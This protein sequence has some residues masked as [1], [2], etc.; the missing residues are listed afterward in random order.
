MTDEQGSTLLIVIIFIIAAALLVLGVN[1]SLTV[2]EASTSPP[3]STLVSSPTKAVP[4]APSEEAQRKAREQTMSLAISY[5]GR[6]FD[7]IDHRL[8]TRLSLDGV[9]ITGRRILQGTN[10]EREY[11][12]AVLEHATRSALQP[13]ELAHIIINEP[14]PEY[15]AERGPVDQQIEEAGIPT[16]AARR[17]EFYSP[18]GL[19]NPTTHGDFWSLEQ[20]EGEGSG[21]RWRDP[22]PLA[23]RIRHWQGNVQ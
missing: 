18:N 4:T 19:D 12:N 20:G 8:R 5:L 14:A 2:R 11:Q 9:E 21:L 7:Q 17:Q 1:S 13:V 3:I 6:K 15:L 10:L 16:V 23:D 22:R